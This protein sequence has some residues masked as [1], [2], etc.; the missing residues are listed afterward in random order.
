MLLSFLVGAG[1][2]ARWNGLPSRLDPECSNGPDPLIGGIEWR[3]RMLTVPSWHFAPTYFDIAAKPSASSTKASRM[4]HRQ[5]DL[6]FA[7]D[8]RAFARRGAQTRMRFTGNWRYI[9]LPTPWRTHLGHRNGDSTGW[10]RS[11]QGRQCA[12]KQRRSLRVEA[13]SPLG[14]SMRRECWPLDML[15]W[16]VAT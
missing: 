9:S 10:S 12:E 4:R 14:T 15:R 7:C 16:D 11:S 3:W 8:H 6:R 5:A 13:T 1:A 2:Q